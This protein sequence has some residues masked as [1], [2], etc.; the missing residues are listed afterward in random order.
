MKTLLLKRLRAAIEEWAQI[1]NVAITLINIQ[2]SGVGSNVHVIVV[3][4][5]GFENWR[6][7]ERHDSLFD[8]IHAKL[9]LNGNLFI[10]RLSA[11]TEEEYEKYEGVEV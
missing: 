7:S 9:N 3:A 8:F 6:R 10:S 5:Q 2:P 4:S 11:M 1:H